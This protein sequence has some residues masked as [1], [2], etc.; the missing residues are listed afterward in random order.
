MILQTVHFPA[1]F[2]PVLASYNSFS[3]FTI[4]AELQTTKLDFS[5][6]TQQNILLQNPNILSQNPE[7]VY[8][9]V[10]LSTFSNLNPEHLTLY[11]TVVAP[12]GNNHYAIFC[13]ENMIIFFL[14]LK[15]KLLGNFW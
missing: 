14:T 1:H 3:T 4:C 11:P 13:I 9:R 8:V 15:K 5:S 7:S 2:C 10:F 6:S 12:R